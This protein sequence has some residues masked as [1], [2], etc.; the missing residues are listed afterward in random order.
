MRPLVFALPALMAAP[1]RET[2]LAHG[3]SFNA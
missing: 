3:G 2:A 1:G